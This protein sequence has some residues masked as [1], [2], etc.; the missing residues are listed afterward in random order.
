MP[1]AL[2]LLTTVVIL[3]A[4]GGGSAA[5]DQGRRDGSKAGTPAAPVGEF[6][7]EAPS[8]ELLGAGDY[9]LDR[10]GQQVT[11]TFTLN[12]MR[13][14]GPGVM[15]VETDDGTY[16][17]HLRSIAQW[18]CD[19]ALEQARKSAQRDPRGMKVGLIYRD[20]PA[21]IGQVNVIYGNGSS[22]LYA[23]RGLYKSDS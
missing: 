21:D 14:Q 4:C 10:V 6:V 16:L 8:G 7:T 12:E 23:A 9:G 3:T 22:I 2:F 20:G 11:P 5:F 15:E 17:I 18:T 13:C 1:I 19:Q